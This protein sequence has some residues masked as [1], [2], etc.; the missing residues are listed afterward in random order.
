MFT[1]TSGGGAFLNG[2][3]LQ[4]SQQSALKKA[5]LC[6]GF[7]YDF[8][9][10]DRNLRLWGA[11]LRESLSVRRDGSAAL[12]LCA[13]A[14]GRFDG[15]WELGLKSWDIAAGALVVTEAGGTVTQFDGAPLQLD[16][17]AILASNGALHAAMQNVIRENGAV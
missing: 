16:G 1:A 7:P 2:K 11:F 12:D 9:Q 14:A 3:R 17:R 6:S 13:V 10:D 5:L 15:F 4:V 8:A